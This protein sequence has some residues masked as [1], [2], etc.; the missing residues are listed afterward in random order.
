MVLPVTQVL[1]FIV[2]EKETVQNTRMAS[3]V[4]IFI[5]FISRS[6]YFLGKCRNDLRV[7][8]LEEGAEND[9]LFFE[10]ISLSI[11]GGDNNSGM[12]IPVHI[13]A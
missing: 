5:S 7:C 1:M 9:I 6:F 4:F 11:G 2:R 12:Y 10:I 8:F 3:E 13:I